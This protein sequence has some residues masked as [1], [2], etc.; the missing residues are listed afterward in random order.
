[1]DSSLLCE[2]ALRKAL[3]SQAVSLLGGVGGDREKGQEVRIG[4]WAAMFQHDGY[5]IDN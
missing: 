4:V 3:P 2:Q 1:M 5:L